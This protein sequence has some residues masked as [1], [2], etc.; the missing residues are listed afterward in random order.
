MLETL[1]S[2]SLLALMMGAVVLCERTMRSAQPHSASQ[3]E[4]D[5]QAL[6]AFEKV[7]TELRGALVVPPTQP[8]VLEFYTPDRSPEGELLLG[9]TGEPLYPAVPRRLRADA[10]GVLW[11]DTQ[12]LARLGEKG[13]MHFTLEPELNL[14]HVTVHAET[15]C[16]REL[17]GTVALPDQN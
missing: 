11:A 17:H 3:S 9:P 14:L 6:L 1:L 10:Q 12:R 2:M 16:V 8:A 13:F 7:R 4:V 5:R 15:T